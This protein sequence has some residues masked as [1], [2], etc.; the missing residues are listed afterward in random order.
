MIFTSNL[1]ITHLNC[2]GRPG[3]RMWPWFQLR[4]FWVAVRSHAT[5]KKR[6]EEMGI[7]KYGS[8]VQNGM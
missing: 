3:E 1:I 5:V 4:F 7:K 2:E 6:E 8:Y